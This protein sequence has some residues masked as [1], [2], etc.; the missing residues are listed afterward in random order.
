[1]YGHKSLSSYF[2]LFIERHRE[3]EGY[4]NPVA[5]VA[6]V[7]VVVVAAAAAVA[8]AAVMV[9][10]VVVVVVVVIWNEFRAIQVEYF[11]HYPKQL[12]TKISKSNST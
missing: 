8:A 7:V 10:V 11:Q 9:V 4:N 12:C 6:V 1:L 5:V 3:I 2:C